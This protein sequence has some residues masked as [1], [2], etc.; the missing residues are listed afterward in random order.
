[1]SVR[2]HP[3]KGEG[4]WIIDY[5]PAGRKGKRVMF[6]FQGKKGEALA[7]EQE[8]RRSPGEIGTVVSPLVKDLIPAWLDYYQNEVASSTYEDARVCLRHWLPHFGNFRPANVSRAAINNYKAVRLQEVTNA[9]AIDRGEEPKYTS[10]RTINKELSYLSSCLKWAAANGHCVDLTFQIKGFPAKQTRAKVPVVLTPRQISKMYDVIEP[11]YKLLFLLMADMGLRR[12]E[13]LS[14]KAEDVDE[15]HETMSVV[16]KGNKERIL[17]WASDRFVDE[18]KKVLD[19]R[20]AGHL[21]INPKTG[22]RFV[23]IRKALNRAAQNAGLNRD[24]NPHLLR[25]SCLTNLA[26]KGM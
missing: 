5:Y 2:P 14:A 9:K 10:K 15:Y 3:K 6:P 24:V 11:E 16:G 22:E 13:A 7:L 20:P 12:E 18:L 8:L 25:H 4:W 19:K 23:Q 1:M 26:K 21:T 17:P